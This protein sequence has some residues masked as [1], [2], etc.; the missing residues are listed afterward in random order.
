MPAPIHTCTLTQTPLLPNPNQSACQICVSSGAQVVGTYGDYRVSRAET[1]TPH[2][3]ALQ[4]HVHDSTS[5]L[6]HGPLRRVWRRLRG[7]R[8]GTAAA[9]AAGKAS[10]SKGHAAVTIRAVNGEAQQPPD[11]KHLGGRPLQAAG[12]KQGGTNGLSPLGLM[13]HK[14]KDVADAS[15]AR[16]ASDSQHGTPAPVS[17]LSEGSVE[18]LFADS[19][20]DVYQI[21]PRLALLFSEVW[22]ADRSIDRCIRRKIIH[23][24]KTMWRNGCRRPGSSSDE[25][26][27]SEG[28]AE[29]GTAKAAAAGSNGANG[30][31]GGP[32]KHTAP[33]DAHCRLSAAAS[34]GAYFIVPGV[35]GYF[36][37]SQLHAIMGPSG[38]GKSTLCKALAGRL[39]SERIC[40]DIRVLCSTA[41]DGFASQTELA[42]ADSK[43]FKFGPSAAACNISHMT[44]F[45]PQFDLLHESLTVRC[46]WGGKVM[47]D[48]TTR[49]SDTGHQHAALI[50]LGVC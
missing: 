29:A 43:G 27:S 17:V 30:S 41:A 12:G 18:G 16:G 20:E 36:P 10:S 46:C 32:L 37:H 50:S 24:I 42:L 25:D 35:S 1:L 13:L 47:C 14:G 45:V 31:T 4:E 40:G 33:K 8:Q 19:S 7:G 34:D 28:D 2:G 23:G 11:D 21:N 48:V 3:S 49:K 22:V 9:T 26:G 5:G 15:D 44:G 6:T 39:P 38:C